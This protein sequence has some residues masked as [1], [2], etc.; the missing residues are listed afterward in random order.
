MAISWYTKAA[1]QGQ[2]DAQY[3]LGLLYQNGNG[4]E[5]DLETAAKWL[6]MSAEGG[7]Q[8]AKTAIANGEI[9]K[10]IQEMNT[11]EKP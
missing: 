3:R 6:L 9:A 5:K 10:V 7:Y 2:L 4:T 11:A 8:P 1:Q